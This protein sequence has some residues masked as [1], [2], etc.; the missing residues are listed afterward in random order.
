MLAEASQRSPQTMRWHRFGG[1]ILASREL[2][3]TYGVTDTD[4]SRPD[5]WGLIEG[6]GIDRRSD[7][8]IAGFR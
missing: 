6:C 8:G 7:E 4:G 3:D 1:K 5:C 2:A